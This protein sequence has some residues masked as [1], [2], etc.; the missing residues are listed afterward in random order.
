MNHVTIQTPFSDE[1]RKAIEETVRDVESRTSGEIAVVVVR[2]SAR[3][4][5]AEV[6]GGAFCASLVA[7]V[8]SVLFLHDSLWYYIVLSFVLYGPSFFLFHKIPALRLLLVGNRRRS[9]AVR[10]RAFQAFYQHRL[11]KTA[12]GT[13][14]LFLISLA[15]RKVVVLADE[16][17][18]SKVEKEK[19]RS[20]A[21]MVSSGM[22]EGR[23]CESLCR[24]I[25]QAGDILALHFPVKSGDRNELADTVR[26][27]A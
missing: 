17:I 8:L 27:E 14:V 2:Q 3:Y 22:K 10:E 16:G 20:L 18:Y 12:E 11:Y 7:L 9:A 26:F 1:D 21:G 25:Q 15:E 24:A 23:P 13:G 6:L 19:F 4:R 5:E